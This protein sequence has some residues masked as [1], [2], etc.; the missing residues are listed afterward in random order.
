MSAHYLS[1]KMRASIKNEPDYPI[2]KV[3]FETN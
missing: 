3:A 2:I 1:V